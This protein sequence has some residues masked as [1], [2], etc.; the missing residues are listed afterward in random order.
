MKT[1]QSMAPLQGAFRRESNLG[2]R[3]AQPQALQRDPVGA[4]FSPDPLGS[5]FPIPMGFRS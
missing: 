1:G 4:Q 5:F 3:F 2:C